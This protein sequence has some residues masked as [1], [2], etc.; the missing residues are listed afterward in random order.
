MSPKR[1]P[2]T[3]PLNDTEDFVLKV[4]AGCFQ[5]EFDEAEGGL[6]D[7]CKDCQREIVT[8]AYAL[9]ATGNYK[10]IKAPVREELLCREVR[11]SPLQT[12]APTYC[13]L[14]LG[15]EGRHHWVT[16]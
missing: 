5:C 15:H 14:P 2:W 8:A 11:Y 13:D 16:P 9:F 3:L 6:V 1:K 4:A 10:I 7:H 12:V